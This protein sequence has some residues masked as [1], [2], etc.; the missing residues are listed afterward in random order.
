[1]NRLLYFPFLCLFLFLQCIPLSAQFTYEE[2]FEGG[3]MP[4]GFTTL[5]IDGLVPAL[6]SDSLFAEDAWRVILNTDL[7]DTYAA[8]SVSWYEND[9]GPADDWMIL[10]RMTIGSNAK[11]IWRAQ[12]TTFEEYPDSYEVLFAEETPTMEN[13]ADLQT[14][15]ILF[16]EAESAPTPV[17]HI[18]NI[19]NLAGKTG[20]IVFRNVTP[21]GDALLVDDISIS[22]V[23]DFP[24][25]LE[26]VNAQ[27][28]DLQLFPNPT[29]D[30]STLQY[31]LSSP[32][33]ITLLLQN[34]AGQT[35]WKQEQG[36]QN[37]GTHRLPITAIQLPTGMYWLQLQ[38]ET[39]YVVEK[40]MVE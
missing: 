4:D 7:I 13:V 8:M 18:I 31:T 3:V 30:Y 21:S 27:T 26:K 36:L 17:G 33:K 5:N 9:A 1:M 40:W 12:S 28:F 6:E 38:T 15:L 34:M 25:S 11:L 23:A 16:V 32:S 35:V 19:S 20:H 10:P 24:T 2:D 29:S 39:E 22:N 37:T 14:E